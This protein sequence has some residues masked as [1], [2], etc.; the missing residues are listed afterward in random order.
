MSRYKSET[1][2]T[3]RSPGKEEPPMS[4]D[5][6]A[7]FGLGAVGAGF[8]KDCKV[9]GFTKTKPLSL[10]SSVSKQTFVKKPFYP[11]SDEPRRDFSGSI[12]TQLADW[13][14]RSGYTEN[15][16]LNEPVTARPMNAVA[17]QETVRFG[18]HRSETNQQYTERL[19]PPFAATP[20]PRV[21]LDPMASRSNGFVKSTTIKSDFMPKRPR[22]M[23]KITSISMNRT[24]KS[25]PAE[26]L[27]LTEKAG[28]TT[29][30][31]H[32]LKPTT[33]EIEYIRAC[34]NAVPLTAGKKENTAY[35]RNTSGFVQALPEIE[36]GVQYQTTYRMR[37]AEP[38]NFTVLKS[39]P[40]IGQVS[41]KTGVTYNASSY[42]RG[43]KIDSWGRPNADGDYALL[44]PQV[45][46]NIL[47]DPFTID[48]VHS[49]KTR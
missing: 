26:Y 31:F 30:S 29:K 35:T 27:N 45:A 14:K 42:A 44:H 21:L 15:S 19:A 10:E 20:V 40:I 48:S 3:L 9:T 34:T 36:D 1:I 11:T 12:A 32:D 16:S 49:H 46:R 17:S 25:N 13:Q 43:T 37:H 39:G 4:A 5:C 6:V 8:S 7:R 38:S 24:Q 47:Q 2:T 33:R 22:S 18:N 41:G 23:S 28:S